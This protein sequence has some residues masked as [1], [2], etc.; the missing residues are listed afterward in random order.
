MDDEKRKKLKT[1]A[2]TEL[3]EKEELREIMKIS[4]DSFAEWDNEDDEI[5]NDL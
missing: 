5:Y 2:D 4:E 3:S 1:T